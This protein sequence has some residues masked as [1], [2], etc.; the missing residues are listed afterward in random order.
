MNTRIYV[1]T[2]GRDATAARLIEAGNAAQAVRH[3]ARHYTAAPAS[4]KDVAH[5][6]GRGVAVEV[7]GKAPEQ[8]A[9]EAAEASL[10]G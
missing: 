3:A 1:V 5:L 8:I 2:D 7:A 6:I 10:R 9:L 4:A